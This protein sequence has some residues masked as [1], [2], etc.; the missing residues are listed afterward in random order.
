VT[1]TPVPFG[2]YQYEVYLQGLGGV[3]PIVPTTYEGLEAAARE[4]LA[5]EAFWYT[6][7]GAGEGHTMT[8]NRAAFDRWQIVPRMLGD[9]STR[10]LRTEVLGTKLS[11]PV[12]M[13]PV[14]VLSIMHPDAEL[15]VARAAAET[16]TAMCLSTAASN[17]MEP[18]AE[19]AGDA[20]RWYQLY[21]PS[22]D[23]LAA[24]FV[25]RAEAAGY[26]A[27]VVTLDT[28]VMPWRPHDIAGAY[29]PFLLGE[30]IANYTSDPVFQ[31][32]VA[33]NGNEDPQAAVLQEWIT[34]F[35]NPTLG[36]DRLSFLREHTSL[37]IVVKGVLHPE[38]AK[39]AVNLG[40]DG[41]V[42][43]NHG[44]RQ[45]DGSVSSLGQLP[46][47]V[48]A[49][50]EGFPVLLDSGIRTGSDVI[51]AISLGASAVLVARPWVWGLALAGQAGV[52]QVL[53]GLLADIEMTMA[54]CGATTIADLNADLLTPAR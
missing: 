9:I 41:I 4:Q 43:S 40:L 44:G 10:D 11:A 38:D 24:S 13:G 3:K 8:A 29:L 21:W 15:A 46:A 51:K 25:T 48:E 50:P 27:I 22:D 28:R 53:R 1:D 18:V 33:A 32:R 31:A 54:M 35:P 6:A 23:E 42:V 2:A 30:G 7:G 47:I 26:K 20:P 17:A 36:W 16:G 45:V 12:M 39:H 5:P 52:T 37:P 34:M 49:V 19:A 14:G